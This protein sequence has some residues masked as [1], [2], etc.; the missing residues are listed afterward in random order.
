MLFFA[1]FISDE[2]DGDDGQY[3]L[4]GCGT[5]TSAEYQRHRHFFQR[6]KDTMLP[7]SHK[8][9]AH[10]LVTWSDASVLVNSMLHFVL[11]F[12]RLVVLPVLLHAILVL[13][14]L[15]LLLCSIGLGR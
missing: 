4:P 11:A 8:S 15:C 1:I 12:A 14:A 13:L 9:H 3:L 6:G 5:Q 7:D 2:A 10:L